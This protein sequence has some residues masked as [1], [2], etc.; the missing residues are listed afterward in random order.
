[1]SS[2]LRLLVAALVLLALLPAQATAAQPE[3]I[4][5]YVDHTDSRF[6]VEESIRDWNPA[7]RAQFVK[8]NTCNGGKPFCADVYQ[9]DLRRGY[10]GLTRIYRYNDG[11][12]KYVIFLDTD[13]RP[14]YKR[15]SIVCHELGHAFRLGHNGRGCMVSGN[16]YPQHPGR[17]NLERAS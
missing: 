1:M 12:T 15:R 16:V 14:T 4:V 11:T 7:P 2:F 5:Y 8:T 6:P 17:Y 13:P 9:R 3:R 10:A